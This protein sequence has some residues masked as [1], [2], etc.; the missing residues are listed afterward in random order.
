[1]RRWVST[2]TNQLTARR[3]RR[4]WLFLG[5]QV[6]LPGPQAIDRQHHEAGVQRGR[7]LQ[8]LEQEQADV[9]HVQHD[10]QPP[11]GDILARRPDTGHQAEGGERGVD[12]R[13]RRIGK[14]D[15][16]SPQQHRAHGSTEQAEQAF[17]QGQPGHMDLAPAQPALAPAPPAITLQYGENALQQRIGIQFGV[18]EN[19]GVEQHGSDTDRPAPANTPGGQPDAEDINQDGDDFKCG[20]ARIP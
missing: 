19:P 11:A 1:M 17:A 4:P 12:P 3:V 15:H 13:H 16:Q 10:P 5:L 14:A 20:H 2:L 18:V 9:D 8:V 7:Q 6:L